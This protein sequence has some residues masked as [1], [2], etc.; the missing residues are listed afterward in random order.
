MYEVVYD[1]WYYF[2]ERGEAIM[3]IEVR[4]RKEGEGAQV[5]GRSRTEER[6]KREEQVVTQA[7]LPL[8]V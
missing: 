5:D 1:V 6:K 2:S 7:L 3:R 4:G 8:R